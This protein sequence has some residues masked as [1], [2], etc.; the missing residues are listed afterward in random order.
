MARLTS[1]STADKD[2][3]ERETNPKSLAFTYV[4]KNK[5]DT[6][7]THTIAGIGIESRIL[8]SNN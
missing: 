7:K 3:K 5:K 4:I 1:L 2:R 8:N 6:R